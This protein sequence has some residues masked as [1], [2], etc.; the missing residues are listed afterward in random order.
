[1]L[2]KF[3]ILIITLLP[4]LFIV[5]D[6]SAASLSYKNKPQPPVNISIAPVQSGL[7]A[8]NIKPG[9]SVEFRVNVL[10]STDASEMRIHNTLDGGTELIAGDLSWSGAVRK[11]QEVIISFTVRAAQKGKGKIT[12]H[13]E[14]FSGNV[15]LYT[16]KTVYELG[17]T[18][19]DKPG[20]PRGV[21]KD[22]KGKGVVEYR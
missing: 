12:S 17:T 21:L 14:I 6:T 9:D 16:S 3:H 11:G 15:L 7:Q 10:P 1:M 20:P 22:S 4:A 18:E 13:V 19:K 5:Q 2:S 8:S